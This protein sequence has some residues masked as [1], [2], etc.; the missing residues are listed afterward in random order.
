MISLQIFGPLPA[1]VSD[2]FDNDH[3]NKD[4]AY[5][6]LMASISLNNMLDDIPLQ[7]YG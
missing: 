2:S 4:N 5:V 6:I 3:K 7:I 1:W